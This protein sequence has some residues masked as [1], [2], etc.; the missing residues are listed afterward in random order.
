M[1]T[2]DKH[3]RAKR[4][5][6]NFL[7]DIDWLFGYNNCE[8]VVMYPKEGKEHI[9]CEVETDNEYQRI[10]LRIYPTFFEHDLHDQ[11]K[12]L[13]HE[14]THTFTDRLYKKTLN[15][16]NGKLETYERINNCNEE[17]TS[18]I[19]NILDALLRGRVRYSKEAYARYLK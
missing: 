6:T 7:S 1:A 11:R 3:A 14:L 17:A 2:K 9:A 16:F 15:L 4:R 8:R 18:R 12:L 13:L 5:I 10:T 19:T